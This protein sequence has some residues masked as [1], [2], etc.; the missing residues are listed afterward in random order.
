M[1]IEITSL[2]IRYEGFRMRSKVAETKMM[3]SILKQGIRDPLMGVD[4]NND[5]RI[6]LDGFKRYRCAKKLNIG[7]VPYHSLGDDEP[8]AIIRL[9][10]KANAKNLTIIEQA[11]L[12]D[13]LKKNHNMTVSEIADL[14]EKSKGWV[15]MRVGII[16]EIGDTIMAK[17]LK[18]DFPVYS[19]MYTLRSFIRMNGIKKEEIESFVKSV[20]GKNLSTREIEVLA[21]GYF[22]GGEDIRQQIEN[23]NIEWGLNRL[24]ETNK[25]ATGCSEVEQRFLKDLEITQK[26]M[27]RVANKSKYDG[28]KTASFYA[29]VDIL[30]G[31]IRRQIPFFNKRIKELHDKSRQTRSYL[32]SS[33][34]GDGT[35]KDS[36]KSTYK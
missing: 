34:G 22:K 28:Y 30:A 11:K 3:E 31:G 20:A 17:I 16:G 21:N 8:F 29:Q 10:R 35:T 26:Y 2:D 24:K 18:G 33:S 15:S 4:I 27:Q 12:I 32:S 7:I 19:Y 5:S 1:E 36:A 14:L 6:L 13:Q 25:P 23:G 9:L